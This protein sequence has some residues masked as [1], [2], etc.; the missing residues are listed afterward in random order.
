MATI[1]TYD[2]PNKHRE[3]K[4]EMFTL[5]YLDKI[6]DNTCGIIYLPNTSLYHP[7]NSAQK[8]RDDAKAIC[9]RL[10]ISLE[11]CI[12]TIWQSWAAI[13]GEKFK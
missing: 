7:T 11:R 8:A 13:C 1:I 3:F 9:Y 6:P 4:N 2:I 10:G 12:S 5:G